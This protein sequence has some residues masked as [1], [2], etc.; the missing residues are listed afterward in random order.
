MASGFKVVRRFGDDQILHVGSR[1]TREEA[2]QL[3]KNLHELWPGDYGVQGED[4]EVIDW[5]A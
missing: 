1:Q 3:A 4:N 2:E 5:L